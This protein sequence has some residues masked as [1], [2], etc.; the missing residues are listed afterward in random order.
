[1]W[2]NGGSNQNPH[3][4]RRATVKPLLTITPWPRDVNTSAAAA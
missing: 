3:R 4:G 1:M 2:E